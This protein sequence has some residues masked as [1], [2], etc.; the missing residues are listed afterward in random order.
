MRFSQCYPSLSAGLIT[1]LLTTAL[2]ADEIDVVS[3]TESGQPAFIT[4]NLGTLPVA[5]ESQSLST[6]SARMRVDND[7]LSTALQ[8]FMQ[9]FVQQHYTTGGSETLTAGPV[10]ADGIGTS[11]V[12]FKQTINSMPVYGASLV[13]HVRNN[14][15]VVY[16]V[17]GEFV[18]DE[19]LPDSASIEAD[20]AINQSLA[21][22][23]NPTELKRLGNPELAYVVQNDGGNAALVWRQ[24]VQYRLNNKL[25]R[26][27]I[28]ASATDGALVAQHALIHPIRNVKTYTSNNTTTIPGTLLCTNEEA[29]GDAIAQEA[30]D[31]AKATYDYYAEKF[32]R[33]SLDDNGFTLISSVHYGATA[34]DKNNAFWNGQQM[35][36]GDGDGEVF[37]PLGGA[38]DV[39]AHEFTHGITTFESNL[40][41]SNESGALNEAMSD[42]FGAAA[43]AWRDGSTGDDTWKIG[44]DVFTPNIAGD[45]LRYMDDP[46]EDNSSYDY[47]PERYTGTQDYGGVHWNSGIANLAFYLLVEGGS[48]PRDKTDYTVPA[49]GLAKAEQI[50]YR[51]QTTYLTRSSNF[52]AARNATAQAAA[53]LYGQAEVDAIH[54]AWCAVGVN[55]CNIGGGGNEL[56]NGVV[57]NNLSGSAGSESYYTLTIPA[58]ATDLSIK[59][60]GG[61]GDADL[62]VKRGSAPTTSSYDCRPYRN[63][64][65]ETCDFAEPAA[66]VWHVMLRGYSAYSGV[67][68][69]ASWTEPGT[70]PG[71]DELENGVPKSNLAASQGD[72]LYYTIQIPQGAANLKVSISGGSGDADLYVKRGSQPTTASYD[73][74]PYRSGNSE[75]CDFAAPEAGTWHVM[76]RAYSAFSNLQLVASWDEDGGPEP[77]DPGSSTLNNLSG[78]AGQ[79]RSY[80]IAVPECASQ[81]SVAMSGGSGDADLYVRANTAPTTS[82]FDCRPYTSGNNESCDFSDAGGKTWYVMIRAYRNYSGVTLQINY[83][84]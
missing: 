35:A 63:G 57:I 67:S 59:I 80:T 29:C 26:D 15:G 60:S 73:C 42:I 18:A 53:D 54:L 61:S 56:D 30:H 49:I 74:R 6:P 14:D 24:T 37:S 70:G 10:E 1:A 22:L 13:A 66:G 21:A 77:C 69:V 39:V 82:T 4:G 23:G 11:H 58:G 3:T 33:D 71:D 12:R 28:F 84:E 76:V 44:E 72:L 31:N 36:Y 64:N 47:Y 46:T 34:R 8:T 43:E 55:G 50:F 52:Q 17:N 20:A 68:L 48:H 32:G 51:A 78:S 45:A 79:T 9:Q 16:A 40:I 38:F 2:S 62:Y 19:D 5:I 75:S 7:S 65:N 25:H 27:E 83:S 81:L 41:Y